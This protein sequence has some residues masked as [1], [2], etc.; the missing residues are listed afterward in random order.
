VLR[1]W[2]NIVTISCIVVAA[3]F[4][5]TEQALSNAPRTASHLPDF[6]GAGNY[7]PL[8]LLCVAGVS[9]LIGHYW[10][11]EKPNQ[12][13]QTSSNALSRGVPH[14]P[15]TFNSVDFFRTA[16]YSPLQDVGVNSIKTEAERV[17]PQDKESFYL[18]ILAVGSISIIYNDIW[19]PLFRSQLLALSALNNQHG[20]VPTS[21]FRKFYD[22]AA[23]EYESEYKDISFDD[24]MAYLTINTLL[25]IHPSEMVEIT[26]KGKDFLKFLLHWGRTEKTKRL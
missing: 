9:W 13:L 16:Y 8:L 3:V 22:E 11:K 17:R 12:Q 2:S 20:L 6:N 26:L 4:E 19:W 14:D 24:W 15:G 7:V 25:T 18:D 10:K 1:A 5:A 21:T 23:K